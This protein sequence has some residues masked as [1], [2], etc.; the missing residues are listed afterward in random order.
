[1]LGMLLCALLAVPADVLTVNDDGGAQFLTIQAA[2]DAAAPGDVIE[3]QPGSYAAFTLAK[4][5]TLLGPAADTPPVIVSGQSNVYGTGD[6]TLAG[7][8]LHRL[9]LADV[10]GLVQVDDCTV[11]PAPGAGYFP[12]PAFDVVRCARVLATRCTITG[13][14]GQPN[15][16]G[17]PALLAEHS[18]VQVVDCVLNA[19]DG[20]HADEAF[21]Y[22]GSGGDGISAV[23]S[24][25]GISASSV[26]GG[27]AGYGT[28]FGG[29][30]GYAGDGLQ[31]S[32]GCTVVLRGE[33]GDVLKAGYADTSFGGTPG[34][35]A[36]LSNT[37]L[38]VSGVA[39]PDAA[40][41]LGVGCSVSKPVP[42]EPWLVVT[43]S[44]LPGQSRLVE[45]HG[46]PGQV[47]VLFGGLRAGLVQLPGWD[48]PFWLVPTN[49]LLILPL[50][51]DAGGTANFPIAL[52]VASGLDG[53]ALLLQ[54]AFP[55]VPS[56]LVPGKALLG[57]PA[58][59]VLRF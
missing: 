40:I 32:A 8:T 54:P 26:R 28:Y 35:A 44:D 25:L 34:Y 39:L 42:A 7:L 6:T 36:R 15:L 30:D 17:S 37:V 57:N 23:A 51:L 5:L 13:P 24:Q 33:P 41:K 49:A 19:G 38:V 14:A 58:N 9:R 4:S 52:P 21:E 48:S 31:A 46:V 55:G 22:G 27:D 20:G 3:V 45:L 59:L 56:A 16:D 10:T 18:S 50:V 43:G 1:M 47:A 11:G 2:I 12:A 29:S 53:A